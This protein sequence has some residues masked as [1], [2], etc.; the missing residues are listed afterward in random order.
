MANSP[1]QANSST[2]PPLAELFNRYLREQAM[3]HQAGLGFADAGD[4]TPYDAVAAQPIDPRLAWDGACAAIRYLLPAQD[5]RSWKVPADW[6][7]LI[8]EHESVLLLPFCIGNFPQLVRD[9]PALFEAT[10][11]TPTRLSRHPSNPPAG[12]IAWAENTS[13]KGPYLLLAAAA[14]RLAG[15]YDRAAKLL[16]LSEKTLP[17]TWK[18]ALANEK[19]A[20]AW[21]QGRI[22]EA[23]A[24]WESLPPSAPVLFNRGLAA[25]VV[26]R[27]EDARTHL[28]AAVAQT[29]ESDAWHHLGRL[30]LALVNLRG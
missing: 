27:R 24:L 22:E 19:G 30:Y 21:H 15:E 10:S 5:L 29:P 9:L 16:A 13:T 11:L 7:T 23:T 26:G 3:A 20:L 1:E 25:L 2:P 18:T 14:L 4:V 8:A 6:P 12:L 17:E 28:T